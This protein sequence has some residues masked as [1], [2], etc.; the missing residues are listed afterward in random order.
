MVMPALILV[1]VDCSGR[2]PS[3]IGGEYILRTAVFY[4]ASP[5]HFHMFLSVLMS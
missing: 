4:K 2:G 1:C 5:E 3:P